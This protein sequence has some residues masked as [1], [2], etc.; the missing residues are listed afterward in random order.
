LQSSHN[1]NRTGVRATC[2]DCHVP[3]KYIPKLL[4]KIQAT[5]ELYHHFMGT[6][7]T[8]E[9]FNAKH[10]ELAERV[11]RRMKK[12]DSREC[13]GCHDAD[14]MDYVRQGQRGMDQHI[15]G[16]NAGETCIDCHKGIVK[17]LPYG[18]KKYSESR[19]TA[20]NI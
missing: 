11:W 9:K 15:E 12:N 3:K 10:Q 13:R 19:G 5:N 2:P 17:P 6:I 4:R 16:L 14:A 7:D 1:T 18:M 20:S 8:E